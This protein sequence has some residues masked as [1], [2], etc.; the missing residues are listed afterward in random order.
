VTTKGNI[1]AISR[2]ALINDDLNAFGDLAQ[3]L[4]AA[5]ARSVEAAVYALILE[6][7]GLGPLQADG[8]PF[9]HDNRANVGTGSALSVAGLDSDAALM[10]KQTDPSG[11]DVLDLTPAILLVARELRGQANVLNSAEFDPDVVGKIQTPN[12]VRG[13]F[14]EVVAS[15]RL[16]GTARYMF[17]DPAVAGALAV[18]FLAGFESPTVESREGWRVDGTELKVRFDF[19]TAAMDPR[20]AVYNAGIAE[21]G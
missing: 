11:N 16:T 14:R 20:A 6:N 4:G 10:A 5:A 8:Q 7:S 9:F 15:A 19:G 18:A 12:R 13:L 21:E 2:Q 1:V 3:R 17:C